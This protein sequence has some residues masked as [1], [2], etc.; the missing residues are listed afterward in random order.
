MARRYYGHRGSPGLE[1]AL[2]HIEDAKEL[3]REL[4]GT[5]RDVKQ[6]FFSLSKTQLRPIL[7]E[8]E[9]RYGRSK[10]EYAEHAMPR[11][12][13][14]R[15]KMSGLVA[16]RLYDLLPPRMPMSAKYDLTKTLWESYCP[17]SHK[18][19]RIGPTAAQDDVINAVRNHIFSTIEN[20][21]I[22]DPLQRRFSWL[23]SG[24]V[25][26]QQQL[27]NHFLNLEK[28]QAVAGTA[29]QLPVMLKHLRESGD[30]I[31]GM[32]QSIEIG[33]HRFDLIYDTRAIELR[34]EEPTVARLAN[35]P[36]S[37]SDWSWI[38]WIV[39]IAALIYFF[40]S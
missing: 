26:V 28:E 31:R 16:G 36:S 25:E 2:Q 39:G 10:R 14:G 5:D 11:W 40:V 34:F 18:A 15:T 4:G 22:P 29:Q 23:S 33:K 6:Y 27:L 37:D 8:Y 20:Y 32:K 19:L 7:D 24:D 21:V 1:A 12:K 35:S 30:Q 17:K 9:R 3:S 38:W 13:S